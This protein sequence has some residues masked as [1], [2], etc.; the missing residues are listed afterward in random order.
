MRK[1]HDAVNR[2]SPVRPKLDELLNTPTPVIPEAKDYNITNISVIRSAWNKL[3]DN[4][5]KTLTDFNNVFKDACNV[6]GEITGTYASQRSL[7]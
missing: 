1:H 4:Y 3:K 7:F 5:I 2:L 6:L